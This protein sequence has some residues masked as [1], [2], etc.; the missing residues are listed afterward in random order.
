MLFYGA[1]AIGT[2]DDD[3]IFYNIVSILC[4]L[5]M[6]AIVLTITTKLIVFDRSDRINYVRNFKK[7]KCAIIYL[8][9]V[10]LFFLSNFYGGKAAFESLLDAV[11]KA[12]YLIALKYDTANVAPLANVCPIFKVA[13]YTCLTLV[14]INGILF[15]FS[16]FHQVVW[17]KIKLIE[18]KFGKR[19]KC[20]VIGNNK[21]GKTIYRTCGEKCILAGRISAEEQNKLFIENIANKPF[22]KGKSI[23]DW[24]KKDIHLLVLKLKETREKINI[25]IVEENEK[26]KLDFCSQFVRYV[27]QCD[28]CLLKNISVVVF[29]NRE[30]EDIYIRFEKQ[31]RGCLIYINEYSQ[32]AINFIEKYPITHFMTKEHLDIKTGIVKAN[33]DISVAMIGF[34]NTN[35]Q[36]FLSMV[37][38]NQLLTKDKE[39]EIALKKIKYHC[40]DKL[41][42]ARHKN[43]NQNYFKY[44]YSFFDKDGQYC[45]NKEDYLELPEVPAEEH[46]H[47]FDINEKSF[48]EDLKEISVGEA[49][50]LTQ[51]IVSL[52]DDYNSLDVA[53]KVV[54]KLKEWNAKDCHVFVRIRDK[55]I[56]KNINILLD[57]EYCTPFGAE[58][59]AVYNYSNIVIEKYREMAIMRNYI[60]DIEKDMEPQT[61]SQDKMNE[62]R[63]KWFTKKSVAERESNLY[64]CLGLRSKLQMF[65]LDFEPKRHEEQLAE[66]MLEIKNL[67]DKTADKTRKQHKNKLKELKLCVNRL[68]RE[69]RNKAE[70]VSEEHKALSEKE[71]MD[72]YAHGDQLNIGYNPSSKGYFV[73]YDLN[74]KKS[75]RTNLAIQ[76]HFRWN[77]FMIVQGFVPSSKNMISNEK[78]DGSYTNGKSYE[79]R[80]HGNITTFEGLKEYRKIIAE[81]D[82]KTE[83]ECDVIKY[84]YQLLDGAYWLLNANGFK[85][86]KR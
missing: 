33:L 11:S 63:I 75:L 56:L 46:Y 81:R 30:H 34:G 39:E 26:D 28:E 9:A 1:Y 72:Y 8:I 53:N 35:Q 86:Y 19:T 25:I 85:I 16:L 62:S 17:E 12:V 15:V 24:F 80:Y 18:F 4:L 38:N 67:S 58:D 42:T 23:I 70:Q 41:H 21:K 69:I 59:E 7:G 29:G 74:N 20:I 27:Q 61:I 47:Y 13:L 32:V 57:K 48:Y 78:A 54:I 77:A 40:F 49:E 14:I 66:T 36:L 5:A 3:M 64:A 60:Y 71:F 79:R 73:K 65:G 50:K 82:N 51:I 44:K 45:V 10:P 52:G 84:D 31:A 2:K 6:G 43:L 76:E 68:R 83:E 55:E 22:V 37:A